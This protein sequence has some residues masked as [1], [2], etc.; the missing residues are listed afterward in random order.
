MG[1]REMEYW[2]LIWVVRIFTKAAA[3]ATGA[4]LV[5][6]PGVYDANAAR[7]AVAKNCLEACTGLWIVAP[8]TRAVDDQSA[9]NLF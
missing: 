6:L 7:A 2:P 4:V 3:L 9:K 8:I 5:D 1:P